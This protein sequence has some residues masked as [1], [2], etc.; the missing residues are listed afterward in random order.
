MYISTGAKFENA[1]TVLA[2]VLSR[3]SPERALTD[4]GIKSLTCDIST[5]EVLG[6]KGVRLDRLNVEHGFLSTPPSSKIKVGDKLEIMPH[7]VGP[8]INL[9]DRVYGVRGDRV[10]GIWEVQARGRNQGLG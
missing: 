9:F 7:L 2:T 4:T 8:V 3:P 1:I 5:A 6:H 10:E